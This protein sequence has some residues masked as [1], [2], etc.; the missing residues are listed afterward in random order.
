M[1]IPDSV[2][3]LGD[4]CFERCRRLRRV[5]FGSSSSLERICDSCFCRSGVKEVIIPD[6]VYE[7]SD[8]CFKECSKLHCVIFGSSSSLERIGTQCFAKS[9]LKQFEIPSTVAS[10][11]G[12]AFAECPLLGRVICRDGCCFCAL[13]GLTGGLILSHDWAR[14]FGSYGDLSSVSIPDSVCELCDHCFEDCKNLRRVTFGSSS[15][16]ER[17]GV[18]C[19]CGSGVEEVSIPDSV[20]ELCDRCFE[21]CER[22][23]RVTFGSSS[24][25]ERIGFNAF[26]GRWDRYQR[27]CRLRE[28]SIPD[29]VCEL[30]GRCFSECESL[31]RVTFGSLSSL[32]RIGICC[33]CET[34]VDE[35]SIPDS[36]LELC[37]DWL[38]GARVFG[39]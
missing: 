20:Y 27:K 23:R 38:I 37:D 30:G 26:G 25:L 29:S 19:F 28:V 17:I 12:A 21:G 35:V 24:S 6:S 13:E 31:R 10:I 16:L 34:G 11:G 8:C 32:E 5:M 9:G 4:C 15:S 1:I 7:L 3:E 22:L 14:C 18:C 36:L 2:Y 33:F 39:A